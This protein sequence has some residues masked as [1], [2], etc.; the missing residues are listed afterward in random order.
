MLFK[1]YQLGKEGIEESQMSEVYANIV[2]QGANV[3]IAVCD[4]ELLGKKLKDKNR[5]FD[6]RECFYK[7]QRM[8]VEE[9]IELAKRCTTANLVGKNTVECAKSEGIVHPDA[10]LLIRNIPHALIVRV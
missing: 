9:A 8:S 7:G 10:V 1:R 2:R 6:I 4:A 3:M 5:V